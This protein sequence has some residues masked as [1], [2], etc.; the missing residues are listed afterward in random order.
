M[1]VDAM[2]SRIA[3][4]V[5]Y[6]Q[7][8][9]ASV[10][11]GQFE[12]LADF[13]TAKEKLDNYF[14]QADALSESYAVAF[15]NQKVVISARTGETKISN[16][17]G[18]T[19]KSSKKKVRY[20]CYEYH[21]GIG[22]RAVPWRSESFLVGGV[23]QRRSY[24]VMNRDRPMDKSDTVEPDP[25][26]GMRPSI[27]RNDPFGAL[28]SEIDPYGI[29]LG[30][31][32]CT[33]VRNSNVDTVL[34]EWMTRW[35]FE[36]ELE[37]KGVLRSIWKQVGS[38]KLRRQVDFDSRVGYLPTLC[39]VILRDKDGSNFDSVVR[40]TWEKYKTDKWRQSQIVVSTHSGKGLV[41]E[42]FD[43]AWAEPEE[44]ETFLSEKDW[45]KIVKDGYSN[46]YKN[47]ESFM[48]SRKQ[49]RDAK[50]SE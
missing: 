4:V 21:D 14:F 3:F 34:R 32:N 9:L 17:S 35:D 39:H 24:S 7:F 33:Q 28:A 2:K 37:T 25:E 23:E 10:V 5:L 15:Q 43:F 1:G 45:S 11:S 42:T 50:K 12:S 22:Q 20:Y 19:I 46:W 48:G 6:F 16:I 29:V 18:M 26:T 41:E 13:T 27:T 38:T 47:F 8:C 40:T 30:G 36:S 31:H 49:G 44:L